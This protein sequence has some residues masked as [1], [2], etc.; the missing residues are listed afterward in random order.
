VVVIFNGKRLESSL[1]DVPGHPVVAMISSGMRRQQPLHPPAEVAIVM[2][3]QDKVKVIGH[4]TIPS[5]SVV[6]P[7]DVKPKQPSFR[8][9]ATITTS[10]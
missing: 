2:G 9:A 4:Q 7:K 8:L 5:K 10:D 3:T 6:R 1:P